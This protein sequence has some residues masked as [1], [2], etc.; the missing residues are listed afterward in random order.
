M[1]GATGDLARRLVLPAF[2]ELAR[3]GLLPEQWRLVGTSRGDEDTAWFRDHVREALEEFGPQ[4]GE[5]PWEDFSARLSYAGGGFSADDA[6]SL[7]AR[8]AEARDAVGA[9]AQLV[10]YLAVPPG[11]ALGIT[12]AIEA[13]GLAEGCRIV[14]EKPY[15]TDLAS[16]EELDA[17]VQR[18]F[19]ESQVF[20]ID[21]FLAFEAVR[22]LVGARFANTLLGAVWNREHVEQVQ[23]DIAETLDVAQRADFYDATGAFLDMI[24]THLF[25]LA[26]T[27]AMETPA[28]LSAD[29]VRAARDAALADFRA[30]DPAE[31]VLGQFEGYRDIDGVADDS[32]TDTLAAVRLWVDSERWRGVPFLLRSGKKMAAD[33]QR[34]T[35]LLRRPEGPL[36]ELPERPSA[37]SFSLLEG[38]RIEVALIVKAL[39]VGEE[40]T[41]GTAALPLP[42]LPGTDAPPYVKLIHDVLTGDRALFTG[43]EGLRNAWQAIE[44]FQQARPEVLPYAEGTWGPDA[45]EE[46]AAPRQWFLR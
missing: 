31:V 34:I 33:E 44:P 45:V 10:H 42:S 38:G 8:V 9:D 4:P 37:L 12:R 32:S 23:I 17:E 29:A 14:Y 15:G 2:F 28:D 5:G 13:H 46:L 18:V 16:F 6:G 35:L 19:D 43:V 3:Q 27:V 21:H 36:T 25:Q 7:P 22:N 20:R 41:T 39:G 30:V 40:L 11:A 26:A 1:Y 24:V